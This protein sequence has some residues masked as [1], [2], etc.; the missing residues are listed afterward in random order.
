MCVG[1]VWGVGVDGVLC[2][3]RHKEDKGGRKKRRRTEETEGQ[4][5]ATLAPDFVSIFWPA[6]ISCLFSHQ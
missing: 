1:W 2:W 6:L 5:V 3:A 4:P